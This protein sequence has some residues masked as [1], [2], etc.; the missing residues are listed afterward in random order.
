MKKVVKICLFILVF[1]VVIGIQK[2]Y[3]EEDSLYNDGFLTREEYKE[4]YGN[5]VVVLA[6]KTEDG[7]AIFNNQLDAL[8][9]IKVGESLNFKALLVDIDELYN[10]DSTPTAIKEIDFED[11]EITPIIHPNIA[12][13]KNGKI[14][15]IAEGD[16]SFR[17][18]YKEDGVTYTAVCGFRDEGL[19]ISKS[20]DVCITPNS[21]RSDNYKTYAYFEDEYFSYVRINNGKMILTKENTTDEVNVYCWNDNWYDPDW[22]PAPELYTFEWSIDDDSIVSIE[23]NNED[24]DDR[25]KNWSSSKKIVA[26]K[27]GTTEVRCKVS[28]L[29]ENGEKASIEKVIN[30]TVQGLEEEKNQTAGTNENNVKGPEKV[31]DD[32]VADRP[33]SKTGEKQAIII[34][35]IVA[36]L[37][38]VYRFK[39]YSK[40]SNKEIK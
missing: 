3:A 34:I 40:L 23:N 17:C 8:C 10:T 27:N 13:V 12:S 5:N 7:L 15:G 11:L 26:K 2:A 16:Y 1:F 24:S 38:L 29:L 32:T 39:K 6:K 4:E 22:N 35:S 14:T 25:Y 28:T 19:D 31:Q 18:T 33:L 36:I 37:F 21:G 30:V 9:S 20:L